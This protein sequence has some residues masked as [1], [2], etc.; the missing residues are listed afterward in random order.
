MRHRQLRTMRFKIW[1]Y[2]RTTVC[3]NGAAC[4]TIFAKSHAHF[5]KRLCRKGVPDRKCVR[6][7]SWGT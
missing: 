7:L 6:R 2:T 3:Y 1:H 4:S 5:D